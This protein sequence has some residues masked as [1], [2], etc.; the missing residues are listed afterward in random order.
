MRLSEVFVILHQNRSVLG[1][2]ATHAGETISGGLLAR[3]VAIPEIR[4]QGKSWE[5][6]ARS[7]LSWR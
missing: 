7:E 5:S 6:E 4:R 1:E 2:G 3:H